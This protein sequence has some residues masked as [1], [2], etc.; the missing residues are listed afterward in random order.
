MGLKPLIDSSLT[1]DLPGGAAYCPVVRITAQA[2]PVKTLN[3]VVSYFG[4]EPDHTRS[5][6][7]QISR[8]FE[9]CKTEFIF[10]EQ[11]NAFQGSPAGATAVSEQLKFLS[12]ATSGLA[13]VIVGIDLEYEILQANDRTAKVLAQL[14]DRAT[15]QTMAHLD[16]LSSQ[17]RNQYHALLRTWEERL[18]LLKKEPGDLIH[19][20]DQI[21]EVTD[22]AKTARLAALIRGCARLAI[23]D[24]SERIH[25]KHISTVAGTTRNTAMAAVTA[26]KPR[27]RKV[28]TKKAISA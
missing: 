16:P 3:S 14:L 20:A 18:P 24:G 21:A 8:L 10:V 27:A 13:M 2:G 1:R 9:G 28:P 26:K 22:N 5:P 19:Y 6:R 25:R 23:L 4:F 17:G 15:I 7:D 12:E 11:F